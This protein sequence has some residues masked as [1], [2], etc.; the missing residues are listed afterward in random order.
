MGLTAMVAATSL[1]MIRDS[2]GGG[3]VTHMHYTLG[4][5]ARVVGLHK[6]TLHRAIKSGRLSAERL[7]DG[8][9]RVDAAELGR[10]YGVTPGATVTPTVARND[11]RPPDA[12]SVT[13]GVDTSGSAELVAE[14][15][16]E[17]ARERETVLRERETVDDLR[18]RLDTA[19]ER[20]GR[21]LLALP[22]PAVV[23][24]SPATA[25]PHRGLLARL[26]GALRPD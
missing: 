10:V 18:R 25:R 24:S 11:A 4:G 21:L 13:P 5:A 16:A 12:T 2:R 1:A 22:A 8:S 3:R 23:T 17:L 7:E 20:V 19:E 14:L 6:T 15:R 9:Y 26:L